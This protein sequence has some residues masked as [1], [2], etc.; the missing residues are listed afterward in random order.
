MASLRNERVGVVDLS[1][2]EVTEGTFSESVSRR[3]LADEHG[4][5]AIILGTGPLT[6]SLIPASCAGTITVGQKTVPIMGHSG[7]ELK[8]TGFDFLVLKGTAAEWGY[9]WVRDGIVEFVGLQ[10]SA[11]LNAWQRTDRIRSD[12]GDS[13]I[14]VL[15]CG[16]WCDAGGG[17][18]QLI[19]NYWG[20]ED[21]VGIGAEF[22]RRR[23]AAV[24]FRGMGEIAI[25][26]PEEHFEACAAVLKGHVQKLPPNRGLRSYFEGPYPDGF[27]TL[28]HRN[29]ACYGCPYPCRSFV[30]TEEDPKEMHLLDREPGYLHYDVPALERA[31]QAGLNS[32]DATRLMM[33]CA[34]AGAEPSSIIAAARSQTGRVDLAIVDSILEAH[35]VIERVVAPNFERS[36]PQSDFA[37][38][39][40]SGLCPRYWSKVGYDRELIR[41]CAEQAR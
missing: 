16:S 1:T 20:G 2:G 25:T 13:K 39:L 9:I 30:K 11:Q 17:A 41:S 3:Q 27:E 35:Q 23:L 8:L 5:D 12:Q 34:R 37:S 26:S 29:I 4:Q 32:R 15:S 21:K 36:L 22:G 38:C 33:R 6:G 18:S 19:V 40:E 31:S 24:A 14:Q 28:V 7:V 10:G